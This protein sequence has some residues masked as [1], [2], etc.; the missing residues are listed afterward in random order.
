MKIS[1]V[2]QGDFHGSAL[3]LLRGSQPAESSTK[4]DDSMFLSHLPSPKRNLV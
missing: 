4:N 3:Q 1:P 2:N